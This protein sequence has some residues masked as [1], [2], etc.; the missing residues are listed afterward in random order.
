MNKK[1]IIINNYKISQKVKNKLFEIKLVNVK[2]KGK[3]KPRNTLQPVTLIS[4]SS[5]SRK[6][7]RWSQVGRYGP[8]ILC[9]H[10]TGVGCHTG[11]GGGVC[12]THSESARGGD[13]AVIECSER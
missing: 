10:N 7:F 8:G 6:V 13:W 11:G 4:T 3:T 12:Y 9:G 5:V 1:Y 2:F